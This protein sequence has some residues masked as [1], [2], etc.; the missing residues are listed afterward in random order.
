[1]T[2]DSLV[3][4]AAKGADILWNAAKHISAT[5]LCEENPL[6]VHHDTFYATEHDIDA[7]QTVRLLTDTR[8]DLITVISYVW[9]FDKKG[10]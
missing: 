2:T 5:N 4:K 6:L 1:M 3:K 9:S 10:N 7:A 8:F